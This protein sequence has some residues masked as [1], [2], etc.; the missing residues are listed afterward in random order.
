MTTSDERDELRQ[1]ARRALEKESAPSAVRGVSEGE[2]GH[3]GA[4]WRT[5]ADLGWMGLGIPEALGGTGSGFEDQAVVLGELGRAVT[6]GPYLSTVVLG[7]GALLA[8]DAGPRRA[9]LLGTIAAGEVNR[10]VVLPATGGRELVV[11]AGGSG[12]DDGRMLRGRVAFVLDAAAAG[13][14]VVVARDAAQPGRV[15]LAVVDP[16]APGVGRRLLPTIDQTR[17]V[18]DLS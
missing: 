6:P 18:A 4:L 12:T 8:C 5:M 14:L 10:A 2:P 3:G 7:A 13:L 9:E 16:D 1:V 17:R 15:L 11:A